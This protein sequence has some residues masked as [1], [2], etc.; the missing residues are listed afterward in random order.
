MVYI[1]EHFYNVHIVLSGKAPM[2]LRALLATPVMEH[3]YTHSRVL[4]RGSGL[5]GALMV[6][7]ALFL[8][9]A[10]SYCH[11]AVRCR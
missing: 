8:V 7:F 2:V 9:G 10:L 3:T 11:L 1:W 5:C 6:H 4:E